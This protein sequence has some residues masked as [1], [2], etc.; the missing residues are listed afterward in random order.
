[1]NTDAI[2]TRSLSLAPSELLVITTRH[3]DNSAG[4]NQ[5]NFLKRLHLTG[6]LYPPP[7]ASPAGSKPRPA[8]NPRKPEQQTGDNTTALEE[9]LGQYPDLTGTLY[10]P[11]GALPA[12]SKPRP[13]VNPRKPEQ[14][15]GDN[16]TALEGPLGQYPDRLTDPSREMRVRYCRSS[17]STKAYGSYPLIP[18]RS[19]TVH[20]NLNNKQKAYIA[21][22]INH[23]PSTAV[24]KLNIRTST[25]ELYLAHVDCHKESPSNAYLP[26]AKPTQ[27]LLKDYNSET[28]QLGATTPPA[29]DLPFYLLGIRIRP[30]VRQ[31][32]NKNIEPGD[33]RLLRQAA[34]EA[35]TRSARTNT[36][37]K[38]R[39]EQFPAK[40][41]R[42]RAAHDGGVF[43][44]E[45]ATAFGV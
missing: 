18:R 1:M 13:A 30:S 35:L 37:R 42:R 4:Y 14:Q 34:L 27:Q 28:Q 5:R 31:R 39:P 32:K 36:P 7:G 24:T 20:T 3:A 23:V 19:I 25:S 40:W 45:E 26:P 44:R 41:R 12:G 11:P 16:T 10:P 22:H 9:P 43:E 21:K 2:D 17:S 33:P 8:V 29:L 38:T 15:T 6:T